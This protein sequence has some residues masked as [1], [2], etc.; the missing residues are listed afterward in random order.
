MV[1]VSETAVPRQRGSASGFVL[2]AV[3]VLVGEAEMMPRLVDHHMA[4][5]LLQP[6]PGLLHL[7]QQRL[8][9]Q[10]DSRWQ[11]AAFPDRGFGHGPSFVEPAQMPFVVEIHR[12]QLFGRGEILNPHDCAIELGAKLFGE[13]TQN[14]FC[15]PLHAFLAGS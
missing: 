8:A 5:Q 10:P 14:L 1:L 13:R 12:S 7:R 3:H 6:D 11:F 2:E 4:D 9:E 15:Q